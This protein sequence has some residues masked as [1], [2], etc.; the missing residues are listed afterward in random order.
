VVEIAGGSLLIYRGDQQG[1]GDHLL[2]LLVRADALL[3]PVDCVNHDA[4]FPVKCY[5]KHSGKPCAV[6]A[7]PDLPTFR[8]GVEVL[9]AL[10]TTPPVIP[11][12]NRR[13]TNLVLT[14]VIRGSNGHL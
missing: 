7:R 10:A 4:Y 5:C 1:D 2:T 3:C 6:L 14:L 8:K 9:A 11:F 13:Q 12:S